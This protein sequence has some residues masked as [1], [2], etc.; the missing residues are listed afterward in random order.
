MKIKTEDSCKSVNTIGLDYYLRKKNDKL[1]QRS[2]Q[3]GRRI[4][5]HANKQIDRQLGVCVWEGR[6]DKIKIR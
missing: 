3:V 4:D 5:R 1:Q 6:S 2:R